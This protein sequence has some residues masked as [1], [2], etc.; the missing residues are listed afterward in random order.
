M[1]AGT[2]ARLEV[3]C[4]E[5]HKLDCMLLALRPS[6]DK[7]SEAKWAEGELLLKHMPLNAKCTPA[8][9]A[10][11]LRQAEGPAAP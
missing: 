10:T 3:S 4:G 9:L 8:W 5:Q 6:F 1:A 7:S 2:R 11:A